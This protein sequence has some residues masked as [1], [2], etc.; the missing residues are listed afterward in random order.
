MQL[1]S[2]SH[3]NF[4]SLRLKGLTL[5]SQNLIV[6]KNA[7]GK[8]RTLSAIDH[9]TG[10]LSEKRRYFWWGEWQAEFMLD[11]GDILHYTIMRGNGPQVV[12]EE[13]Q[14]SRELLKL[15]D[16]ILIDRTDLNGQVSCRIFSETINKFED[17]TPPTDQLVLHI[18]R[19]I[20]AYPY[21]EKLIE[22]GDNAY[23]FQFGKIIPKDYFQRGPSISSHRFWGSRYSDSPEESMK[24]V[25]VYA[26]LPLD[27]RT[28]IIDQIQIMGYPLI[29]IDII[30][31]TTHQPNQVKEYGQD[32][33][34][35]ESNLSTGLSAY[36]LSQG[37]F[38]MISLLVYLFYL[39][40]IR[41][42]QLI[43]IDDLGEGLDYSRAYKL[44]KFIFD[45]CQEANVQLI[46]TSNDSFL[47]DA[48]PI[49]YWNVLRRNGTEI[50]ALNEK[51]HPELFKQFVYTGL[52]NF[53]FFSSDYIDSKL[54]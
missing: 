8:S 40:H 41:K 35:F 37:M 20:K 7:T 26:A 15:N 5:Q 28:K 1:V 12:S 10:L 24:L 39:I 54:Q 43:L 47:M 33:M 3:D 45:A 9:F 50:T 42:L 22:W 49:E 18:R 29:L 6:G 19:D 30:G 46:A 21:F 36:D 4:S 48:I 17:F 11:N 25:D 34:F 13:R 23:S 52:S 27:Q 38:R 2:F 44:G 51:N 53:D 16:Q 14:I 32:L 31:V